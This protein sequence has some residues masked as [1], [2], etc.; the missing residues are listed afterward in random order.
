MRYIVKTFRD[1][2]LEA[3]W[4]RTR[5]GAPIIAVRDPNSKY[6]HQRLEWWVVDQSM[7][8]AMKARGVLVG[9]DECT[10]L[11]DIFSVRV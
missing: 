4:S 6:N 2:G 11:G 5:D 10:A 1:A 8:D 7:W 9:F 3:H